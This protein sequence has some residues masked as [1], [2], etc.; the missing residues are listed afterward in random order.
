MLQAPAMS[1]AFNLLREPWLPVRRASGIR[2]FIQISEIVEG[3]TEDPVVE[4]DWPRPDFR[5]A[6]LEFLIS[7]L[8]TACPSTDQRSW[9]RVWTTPPSKLELE[10][11]LAPLAHAFDLDGPGPRFL[12]DLEDLPGEGEPIERLLIEAPGASTVAKNTDLL[13]KRE[14]VPCLGRPAAAIALYT[15]QSWAPAGGAG[16]RTGL[17]GGGPMVTLV[18]PGKAPSLWHLLW[19]NTPTGARPQT[20]DLPRVFPWL[21]PTLTSEGSCTVVPNENAHPLQV[22]WGMPRRIRLDFEAAPSD[23][24][25]CAITGRPDEV[26]VRRWRQR[27]RGANYAQWG[28][29][30]PLTPHYQPKAGGEY[31]PLHP[32]PGGV[33]YRHWLGLVLERD[34]GQTQPAR[35]VAEWR[36]TRWRDVG[37]SSPSRLLVAGFDM[38]N[39][40]ARSFV[41][42]EMPLPGNLPEEQAR[43]D[44]LAQDLVQAADRVA[45]LL[46]LAVRNALFSPG[47]T[48]KPDA[49]V[50]S[51]ARER[52]WERTEAEFFAA[53]TATLA[54]QDIEMG[55]EPER[56]RWMECLCRTA[57]AIFDEM[58]PLSPGAGPTAAARLAAARRGLRFTLTGYGKE[59][60]LLFTGL[61]LPTPEA[62]KTPKAAA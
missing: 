47:A 2:A 34:G 25:R 23:T 22:F 30:H 21:A 62:S 26:F 37:A 49:E 19:A 42:S 48:V 8:A 6:T 40:K 57:F 35:A 43:L 45:G 24:V 50:L 4:F 12:Q 51:T 38:D 36:L 31:L 17:R 28:R 46:R 20:A 56:P 44:R 61:G 14:Q 54:H 27:P 13:I 9:R 10:E 5:I 18:R 55:Q 58:A 33:G 59:G 11:A 1:S 53:L 41:E 3:L 29:C 16:N 15:L 32:Q 7:L 52:L 60:R 39:M